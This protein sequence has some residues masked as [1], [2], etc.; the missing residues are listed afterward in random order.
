[1]KIK[2]L[3][4]GAKIPTRAEHGS[5]GYDVIAPQDV[6]IN[7]GRNL[8]KLGFA[9][10][11]DPNTVAFNRPKSGMSLRGMKGHEIT[12]EG[13]YDI[14]EKRFDADVLEGTI[15]ESF[16]GECGTIIYSNE[17]RPFV[18]VKGTPISQLVILNYLAPDIETTDTLSETFRAERGFGEM[19]KH[20]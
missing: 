1:M 20:L 9:I 8:I 4:E 10:E 6:V 11:L 16:R 3:S 13:Q 5:A 14:E 18:I 12:E 19:D 15:D 17:K 2:L 7:P